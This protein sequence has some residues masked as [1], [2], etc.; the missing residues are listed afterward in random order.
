[1]RQFINAL[2]L[3]SVTTSAFA[4][5]APGLR[6]YYPVPPAN[7]PKVIEADLVVYGGTPGGVTAAIQATRMGKKAVIFSFNTFVGGLTSGG[8]TATDVGNRGA[9]GGMADEFF[10]RVG[11][12]RDYKPSEAERV[13]LDMPKEANVPVYFEHR[14]IDLKKDG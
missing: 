11:K 13:Y 9:I 7:P 6:Y 5:E 14:L 8:L 12:L 2:V 3:L 10:K 1:M 4:Q